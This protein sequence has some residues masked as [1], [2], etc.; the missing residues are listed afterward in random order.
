MKRSLL[1]IAVGLVAISSQ[2]GFAIEIGELTTYSAPEK[3]GR[4]ECQLYQV[5][6]DNS[7]SVQVLN[8]LSEPSPIPY[9]E[10]GAIFNEIEQ[11]VHCGVDGGCAGTGFQALGKSTKG[12]L[13]ML[14]EELI[15]TAHVFLDF[16][17]PTSASNLEVLQVLGRV[18][19]MSLSKVSG[20]SL[21][22]SFQVDTT[23]RDLIVGDS[24]EI[25]LETDQSSII[26][27]QH[28]FENGR[29]VPAAKKQMVL[30]CH[31]AE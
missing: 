3:I 24:F 25:S 14:N 19:L 7:S 22:R 9:K 30:S 26:D 5:D 18:D 29:L 8:T 13:I 28:F 17:N 15:N 11:T 6:E 16:T 1:S 21:L 2:T 20:G 4:L 27:F 31:V 10:N 23:V 12:S